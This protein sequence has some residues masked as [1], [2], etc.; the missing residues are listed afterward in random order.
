MGLIEAM[1]GPMV[2]LA[3][4]AVVTAEGGSV[5]LRIRNLRET[6]VYLHRYQKLAQLSLV[7]LTDVVSSSVNLTM[8]ALGHGAFHLQQLSMT[9]EAG[10]PSIPVDLSGAPLTSTKR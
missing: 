8:A 3:A 10:A 4:K 5:P 2:W 1:P 6:P 7:D 9:P